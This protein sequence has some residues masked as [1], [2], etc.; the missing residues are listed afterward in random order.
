MFLKLNRVFIKKNKNFKIIKQINTLNP[1]TFST[2]QTF[3]NLEGNKYEKDEITNLPTRSSEWLERKL[4]LQRNHPVFLIRKAVENIFH[5]PNRPDFLQGDEFKSFYDLPRATT[6]KACF[7]DLLIPK[8]HVS[9]QPTDTYFINK[10]NVLRCHTSTHQI[11]LLK[12]GNTAFLVSG[13]VYRR[14]EI[15]GSH[16]PVFHQMEGV[17]IWTPNMRSKDNPFYKTTDK[18]K[19]KD[20][21]ELNLKQ[22]L[23]YV[24]SIIFKP[25]QISGSLETRWI[26]GYFPFTNPSI[27]LEVIYNNK[28]LEILGCGVIHPKVLENAGLPDAVGWAFGLGLERW[29]MTMFDIPDI[30]LF[31][32]KDQRFLDQFSEKKPLNL[33]KFVPFSKYP[34][35][36]KD[37]TFWLNG[38][39]EANDFFEIIREVAGDLVEDVVLIDE[40]FSN[41]KNKSS[42]CYRIN[43]RSMDRNLTNTE[44]DTIQMNVRQILTEK[45]NITLR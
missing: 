32:S 20:F 13:D 23:E 31:W 10:D 28:W 8:E 16:F 9:R 35:C 22:T 34:P 24:A 15:D 2:N 12:E 42:R 3:I 37:I 18:E 5:D 14:D 7:D 4:H 19:L 38:T 11:P 33:Q 27:E 6:L 26:P 17:R 36:Y 25:L 45:L 41:T 30:R 44:I 39:F 29:A 40:F 1:K 43:Y 21:C